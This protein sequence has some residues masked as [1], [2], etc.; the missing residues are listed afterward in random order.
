MSTT[1]STEGR[2]RAVWAIVPAKLGT[3]AKARLASELS[4]NDRSRFALA[5]LG[6][7]L[8]AL[9]GVSLLAGIA[10]VTRDPEARRSAIEHGA[11]AVDDP[12]EGGLNGAVAAGLRAAS[13]AGAEAV[14]VAMGDLPLLCA[15]EVELLLDLLPER[16]AVAA[17]SFDG[18]GTNLLALQPP[19]LFATH[20]GPGSLALH[21]RA[22]SAAG[23]C[24]LEI[25]L[26]GATLDV[27]TPADLARLR[28][29]A[30]GA[31]ESRRILGT[32]RLAPPAEAGPTR[33][34]SAP[35]SAAVLR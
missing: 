9:R 30:E 19:Q 32:M 4:A 7:V 26:P 34:G 20:F 16:G 18:T 24:L 3:E 33:Q 27:D 21:R 17:R 8:R 35:L 14:L 11:R 6:D 12:G 31:S 13:D 10:V 28:E 1:V 29:T 2:K 22:A 5:M 23:I 15:S 25:D